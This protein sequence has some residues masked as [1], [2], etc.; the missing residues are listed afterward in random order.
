MEKCNF[1]KLYESN[2]SGLKNPLLVL[3][4]SIQVD[5]FRFVVCIDGKEHDFDFKYNDY[6]GDFSIITSLPFRSKKIKI[7]VIVK[8]KRFIIF[9]LKNSFLRRLF[10]RIKVIAKKFLKKLCNILSIF[11]RAIVLRGKDI[12][13]LFQF[14]IGQNIIRD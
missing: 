11:R 4:G 1:V 9:E 14:S 10:G 13:L 5:N 3:K 6:N 8:K 7:E 2:V 12:I